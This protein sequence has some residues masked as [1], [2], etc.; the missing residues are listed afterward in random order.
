MKSVNLDILSRLRL[1]KNSPGKPVFVFAHIIMPH[2]PYFFD[3]YGNIQE[4]DSALNHLS[5]DSYL[6][7]LKF[8]NKLIET[9]INGITKN[10]S[11]RLPVIIIQGDHGW[12]Y[13]LG[14]N[15]VEESSTILNAYFFP[16]KDSAK[17]YSSIS[18]VNTF[19]VVFNKYLGTNLEILPDTTYNVFI[20][21]KN[22][23]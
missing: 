8:L 20:F 11:D 14:E 6:G 17:V 3:E 5:K 18:P 7:Q 12:R 22:P 9:T 1:R 23:L 4:A 10:Y 16:G 15:E 2:E 13:L 19:R 21:Q